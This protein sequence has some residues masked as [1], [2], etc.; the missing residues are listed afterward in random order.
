MGVLLDHG[1]KTKT[2]VSSS[3][4]SHRIHGEFCQLA[5]EEKLF[6]P[7]GT[8]SRAPLYPELTDLGGKERVDF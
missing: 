1:P 3:G 2:R 4:G 8:L 6:I 7:L 5:R